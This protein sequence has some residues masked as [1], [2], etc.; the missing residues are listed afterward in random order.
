MLRIDNSSDYL[1]PSALCIKTPSSNNKNNGIKD[2]NAQSEVQVHSKNKQNSAE[3]SPPENVKISLN[4]CLACSG[5]VTSSET[6]LVQSQSIQQLT[7]IIASASD[8]AKFHLSVTVSEQ[9]LCS[10]AAKYNQDSAVIRD[11]LR[12]FFGDFIRDRYGLLNEPSLQ[13]LSLARSLSLRQTSLDFVSRLSADSQDRHLPLLTG[14]CPGWVC[15]AE[16]LHGDWILPHIS[17]VKSPQQ[18]MGS[19]VKSLHL[20]RLNQQTPAL[21]LEQQDMYHVCVMPCFDKKLEAS[22]KD[23][24]SDVYGCRDV[25]LVL[26]SFELEDLIQKE[27]GIS[28][29]EILTVF[30]SQRV[31]PEL[32]AVKYK[33]SIRDEMRQYVKESSGGYL[34]HAMKH[35]CEYGHGI[36]FYDIEKVRIAVQ[37]GRNLDYTE[38]KMTIA[39][40]EYVFV[41]AYG[42]RNIQNIIRQ[43]KMK[44]SKHI[45]FIE[46]MACPSGCIN[47]GGQLRPHV[48]DVSDESGATPLP[49]QVKEMVLKADAIY[50]D[51]IQYQRPGCEVENIWDEWCLILPDG[52]V[53]GIM[54]TDYHDIQSNENVS[55]PIVSTTS[56]QW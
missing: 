39:G 40:S 4:D 2:Q 21:L 24:Y 44:K 14:S 9:S 15:F 1:A 48:S 10:F 3:P 18:I 29:G 42:F 38:Y 49:S 7:E 54:Y 23:F 16:K 26:A 19:I 13:D 47:G 37:K 36:D 46:V 25:D 34:L 27:S 55:A 33:S 20:H 6:L 22:R 51:S 28:F 41:Q 12:W 50:H 53:T 52:Q 45:H 35:L 5:C 43:F 32:K 11:F 8:N 17:R 31:Q 30:I 56:F